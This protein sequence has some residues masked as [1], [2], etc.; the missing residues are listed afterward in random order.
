VLRGTVKADAISGQ[1]GND[2]L[3]GL[4]GNDKLSGGPGNDVLVGGGGSDGLQC[5]PGQDVAMAAPGDKVAA[6]CETVKG[7]P[8]PAVTISDAFVAEGNSGTATLSFRVE[9]SAPARQAASVEFA[10][11]D[12][13][14][15]AGTDYRP[16][17]GTLTFKPGETSRTISVTTSGDTLVEPDETLTVTLSNLVNLKA[18]KAKATGTIKN[19]DVAPRSGHYAGQSSQGK[20]LSFDVASDV[21]SFTNFKTTVDLACTEVPVMLRDIPFDFGDAR[22]GLAPDWTFGFSDPFSEAEVSGTVALGGALSTSGPASGTLQLDVAINVSG[23]TV[24]CSSGNVTWTA[25]AA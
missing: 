16:A 8:N 1:A 19:D 4:A 13:T 20:A 2:R 21:R 17:T 18:A 11:V 15:S 22:I 14:A 9:L 24:H 23:G 3:F 7:L 5:G 25:S 10:T 12:G 6:D